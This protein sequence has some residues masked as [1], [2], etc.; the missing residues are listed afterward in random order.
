MYFPVLVISAWALIA[1]NSGTI[2]GTVTDVYG[3]VLGKAAIQATNVATK[4]LFNAE[5][6]PNGAYTLAQ[7]PAGTYDL[8]AT[9][10]G[11]VPFEQK[12]I[13]VRGAQPV[14]L[15]INLR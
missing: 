3:G 5:S 14:R 15:N 6:S 9:V 4:A 10:P 11:M 13:A 8:S 12:N 2:T 1:Q 7:L